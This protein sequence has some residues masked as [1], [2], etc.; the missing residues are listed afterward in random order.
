MD[1]LLRDRFEE[2]LLPSE[3]VDRDQTEV[4][5]FVDTELRGCDPIT[6]ARRTFH[7]VRDEVR[8]SWD[9]QGHRVT[10]SASEA[11]RFRE[12][13]CYAKSH[14]VAA[15]LRR[16]GLPTALCYQRLTLFDDERGGFALHA[17]NAVFI[18]NAWHRVDARG[19]RPGVTAEFSLEEER[20]A[21]PVRSHLGEVDYPGLFAH[22]H[23]SIVRTLKAHDDALEM[24]R[25]GLPTSLD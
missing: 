11:L 5:A 24:Y 8:H 1:L 19:N 23:P 25:H 7:F 13:V 3:L 15:I 10:R 21:F 17:L 6:A 22:P 2:Y 20:L 4:A 12:G 14:L 18:D 16:Y 9:V